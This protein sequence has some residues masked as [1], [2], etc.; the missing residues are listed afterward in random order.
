MAKKNTERVYKGWVMDF[1]TE[2]K[3]VEMYN[4]LLT[5]KASSKEAAGSYAESVAFLA[6]ENYGYMGNAHFGKYVLW[7]QFDGYGANK[8]EA[9]NNLL[10]FLTTIEDKI[11]GMK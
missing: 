9:K 4:I 8:S 11:A 2:D 3:A 6:Q 5:K 1:G 10:G 7:M